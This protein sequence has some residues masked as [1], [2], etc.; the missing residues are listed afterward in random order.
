MTPETLSAQAFDRISP[1]MASARTAVLII[2]ERV[3]SPSCESALVRRNDGTMKRMERWNKAA[4]VA[5]VEAE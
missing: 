2:F 4:E 3:I 1:V 5:A